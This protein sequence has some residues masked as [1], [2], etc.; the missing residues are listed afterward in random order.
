M[1]SLTS[2]D[3]AVL[4]LAFPYFSEA[5]ESVMEHENQEDHKNLFSSRAPKRARKRCFPSDDEIANGAKW[6]SRT[7]T[8]G[9]WTL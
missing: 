6:M 7:I 8:A 2:N 1:Y 5:G 9:S 4:R 3:W